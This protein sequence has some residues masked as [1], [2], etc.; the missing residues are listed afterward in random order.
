MTP[1]GLRAGR[2]AGS[3]TVHAG[4]ERDRAR[5]RAGRPRARR[6]ARPGETAVAEFRFRDTVRLATRGRHFA[7]DVGGG[8]AGLLVDLRDVPLR[9][10]D[11]A[12][13]RRDLLA[14]WQAGAVGRGATRMTA[15][16]A[17]GLDRW[18]PAASSTGRVDV[19]FRARARATA[20]SWPPGESVV[21]GTPDRRAAARR[22]PDR[23]GHPGRQRLPHG[24]SARRRGRAAVR[25]AR[26]LARRGRR[27]DRADRDARRGHRPRGPARLG[28]RHQRRPGGR[29]AGIVALGGPTHGRLRLRRPASDGDA[30]GER[31]R[32]RARR[33]H[34]RRRL[35]ARR[36]DPDP[37]AGDGRARHHRGRAREQGAARL[38]GAPSDASGRPSTAS[39]R[40]P[41]SSS[42][43][44][45]GDPLA[46]AGDGRPRPRSSASEVAIVHGSARRSSS[47]RPTS[48]CR[49]RRPDRVR[50][51]GGEL[52]GREGTLARPARPAPLRRR[53]PARGRRRALQRRAHAGRPDRRPRAVHLGRRPAGLPVPSGGDDR[54]SRHP[55]TDRARIPPPRPASARAL[56]GVAR[57]GDLDLP[58]GRPRGRQDPPGQGVRRRPRGDR[59]DRLAELRADGRVRR[60]ACRCSTSTRTAWPTRPTPS[61]AGSSTSARPTGV[62]LIEWPERLGD[63]LPQARLDVRIDGSGD[64]PR[65]ITLVAGTP[66]YERYLRGRGMSDR[67]T[68]AAATRSWPSTP[69][70]RGSSS[71]PG[72]PDGTADG[73]STWVAGYRH[74]ETLLPSIGRFLGEQNLRR[75]RLRGDRRRDRPGRVHRAARRDGHGQGAGPR[76]RASRSS[77]CRPARRCSRRPRTLPVATSC[78]C[79]PA[80]SD[81]VL[82]RRGARAAPAA[83]RRPTRTSRPASVL[84][85]VDLEGR[86]PADAVA[87]GEAAR[88]GLGAAL[89]RL[90]AARA[91]GRTR[92]A[93]WPRSCPEYVTLPRGAQPTDGTVAWSR[94]PR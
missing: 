23:A 54:R 10:P 63:A 61:P 36:R 1:A 21:A 43:A 89:L 48:T 80:P 60:A 77:A 85:A 14:A 34:P 53:R 2:S 62:T 9:L 35:A 25:V 41:C 87:R 56:A 72:A 74:G 8:L 49:D 6:P 27:H 11:R 88:E 90:G 24:R 30:A 47:T 79:R 78:S 70:R 28:H 45:S 15:P 69:R 94:D 75:S 42:R 40:S 65:T 58:V 39:R 13:R 50:V 19:T 59:H 31:P 20:R 4:G 57:A 73:V 7:V 83:R 29:C 46:G 82:V 66:D 18:S 71:R 22:P 26:P 93:S 16:T 81:R 12:D 38:P 84:V 51:R 5:P 33:D 32:R 76:A 91:R 68:T 52:G 67:A 17:L 55:P 44:R 3:L 37:G 86:A 92:P 64:D